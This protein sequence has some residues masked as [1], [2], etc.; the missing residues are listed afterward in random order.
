MM[1]DTRLEAQAL[2]GA[3]VLRIQVVATLNSCLALCAN[4][5]GCFYWTWDAGW[6]QSKWSVLHANDTMY[7]D[8]VCYLLDDKATKKSEEGSVS[9]RST[10]PNLSENDK[11]GDGSNSIWIILA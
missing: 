3:A 10:C 7:S 6:L 5:P 2:V 1:A 4:T 8:Q 11:V 9:G